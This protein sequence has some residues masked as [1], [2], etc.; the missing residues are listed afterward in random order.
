MLIEIFPGS[1]Y[2]KN[3]IGDTTFLG[4]LF[5]RGWFYL[6]LGTFY[7]CSGH[8]VCTITGVYLLVVGVIFVTLGAIRHSE[9]GWSAEE[10]LE[11]KSEV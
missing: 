5:G 7:V 4:H 6:V 2:A 3:V 9:E 8:I 10:E 1:T 11:V